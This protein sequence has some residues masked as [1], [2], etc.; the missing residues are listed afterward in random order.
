MT[1]GEILDAL[2]FHFRPSSGTYGPPD[3]RG[4]GP[5]DAPRIPNEPG[6][7]A[8]P[9]LK[10]VIADTEADAYKAAQQGALDRL[11]EGIKKDLGTAGIYLGLG[12]LVLVGLLFVGLGG[13]SA[14]R[15]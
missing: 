9:K 5:I 14:V 4:K 7:L 13:F 8:G 6:A 1:L 15:S 12:A 3:T 10:K 11:Y 2:N